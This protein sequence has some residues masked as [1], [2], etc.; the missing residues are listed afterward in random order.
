MN[1]TLLFALTAALCLSAAPAP[2]VAKEDGKAPLTR[3]EEKKLEAWIRALD[4]EEFAAREG[5]QESLRAFGSR[6]LHALREAKD[7]R[8]EEVRAR[9]RLLIT[10]LEASLDP[11]I[12]TDSNWITLKG[13][14]GRTGARGAAPMGRIAVKARNA[15]GAGRDARLDAPMA[16]YDGTLVVAREDRVIGMDATDLKHKWAVGLGAKIMA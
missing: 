14:M 9:V 2:G 16:L 15:V 13:D 10:V 3:A 1:R 12:D 8:S 4:D 6:A 5:A 7:S 11:E